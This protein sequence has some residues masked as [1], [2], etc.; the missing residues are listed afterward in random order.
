[1]VK[2]KKKPQRVKH[3][4]QR[5]C[6]VCRRKTDKRQLTRIVRTADEGV[7]VDP[8]G[9][10]NGRGAYICDHPDC[11]QKLTTDSKWLNQALKTEVTQAELAAIA[12]LQPGPN[13]VGAM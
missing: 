7:V 10:R 9:K 1:M 2:G 8:T 6:I 11:W 12:A 3:V 13:E 5:S 4:P